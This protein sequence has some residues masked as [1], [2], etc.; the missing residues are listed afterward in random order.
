MEHGHVGG[1]GSGLGVVVE[2]EGHGVASDGDGGPRVDPDSNCPQ[3]VGS[4]A[5]EPDGGGCVGP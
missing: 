3:H 5:T 2:G 1:G 4:E